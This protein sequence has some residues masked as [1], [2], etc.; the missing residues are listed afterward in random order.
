[1]LALLHGA[2]GARLSIDD[3][4]RS[5]GWRIAAHTTMWIITITFL[6]IGTM[7]I[8]TFNPDS[9]REVQAVAGS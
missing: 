3:Y 4:I 6:V 5:N 8:V 1:L 7:A 2:N 9:F